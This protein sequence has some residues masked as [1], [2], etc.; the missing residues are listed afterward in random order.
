MNSDLE[1]LT[2][3]N[4]TQPL[5]LTTPSVPSLTFQSAAAQHRVSRTPSTVSRY[6][7]KADF[8]LEGI[9]TILV[10]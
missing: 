8:P 5:A 7:F 3:V 2:V 1:T 6:F 10:S 4:Q 9:L